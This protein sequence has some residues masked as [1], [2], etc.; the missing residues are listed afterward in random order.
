MSAPSADS[1]RRRFGVY[2]LIWRTGFLNVLTVARRE[3]GS[4]FVSAMAWVVGALVILPVSLFGYILPVL[5]QNQASMDGV[6]SL[7]AFLMLF[8]MPLYTMRLLAEERRQGTLEMLLTSPLRDWEL[9]TGKW[10]GGFLFFVATIAFTTVY[11][12]LFLYYLQ[13]RVTY[14]PFGISFT[15]GSLDWGTIGSGYAG[16]LL[17]GATF[18]AVG[19]FA[20]SLTQNQIIAAVLGVVGLLL[21]WYLG[22]FS[23]F[24]GAPYD[25]FFEYVGAQN[26]YQAFG[27]G[28]IQL[29]DVVY[30]LSL[31]AGSLFLATRVIESRRW[32]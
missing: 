24:L 31:I 20:S 2:E 19:V 8:L 23:Q 30:F 7:L 29:K 27:R 25:T 3:L 18:T 15:V 9:V 11:I 22:I 16:L 13:D 17:V 12:G 4:Y 28:L 6:F 5:T 21:L 10:L 1:N 32:R 14:R 26:R